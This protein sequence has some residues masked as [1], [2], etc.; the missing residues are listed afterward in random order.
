LL[1]G[2]NVASRI[3]YDPK[4]AFGELAAVATDAI[5]STRHGV[6]RLRDAMRGMV[7][8]PAGDDW[9]RL[10]QEL[11]VEPGRGKEFF[12]VWNDI[13]SALHNHAF[14]RLR[15]VDEG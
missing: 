6:E 1:P 11:G 10:E 5:L 9:T 8:D 14:D 7:D 13:Y 4:S 2:S 3:P 15:D 12:Q